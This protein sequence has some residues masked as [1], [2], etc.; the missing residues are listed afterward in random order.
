MS[1]MKTDL[2]ESK[3]SGVDF[4]LTLTEIEE[5]PQ[6]HQTPS[7]DRQIHAD[8]P[9]Q[10]SDETPSS[11]SI[12]PAKLMAKKAI[13]HSLSFLEKDDIGGDTSEDELSQTSNNKKRKPGSSLATVIIDGVMSYFKKIDNRMQYLASVFIDN[14]PHL[15]K[16]FQQLQVSRID[17]ISFL[18]LWWSICED[19]PK[20]SRSEFK[21]F[22]KLSEQPIGGDHYASRMFREMNLTRSSDASSISFEHWATGCVRWCSYSYHNCLALAFRLMS[23]S[24][25]AI[26]QL[27]TM[28]G[29][30][31]K[32][33]D[34]PGDG[35]D[36]NLDP[37]FK[38]LKKKHELTEE[39][40]KK[41]RRSLKKVYSLDQ[42]E[43]IAELES[44]QEPLEPPAF[45]LTDLRQWYIVQ[46]YFS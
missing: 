45:D 4:D 6:H 31:R 26:D 5:P 24:G 32:L 34:P 30:G 13:S 17:Q 28:R 29:D 9:N 42:N 39:E 22:Y 21:K 44:E 27:G 38:K 1:D 25:G 12:H 37:F 11:S 43:F 20:M 3:S 18:E 19:R 41:S 16:A 46:C 14:N 35:R 10:T 8:K 33:F 40:K 2:V 23:R 36:L 15:I 7:K